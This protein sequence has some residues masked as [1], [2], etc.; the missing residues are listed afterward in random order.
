MSRSEERKRAYTI[1]DAEALE[2]EKTIRGCFVQDQADFIAFGPNFSSPFETDW[3][4]EIIAAE[5]EA[6]DNNILSQQSA[7]TADVAKWMEESKRIFQI[8]KFYIEKT[9]PK[10]TAIQ[11]EFGCSDYEKSRKSQ[12]KM[13]QFMNQFDKAVVVFRTVD[14]AGLYTGKDR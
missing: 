2:L 12:A 3:L 10:N 6:T 14:R 8:T 7:L 4:N 5:G 1:S 11:N 13:V 9:F